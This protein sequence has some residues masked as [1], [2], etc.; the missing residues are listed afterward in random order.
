MVSKVTVIV[1]VTLERMTMSWELKLSTRPGSDRWGVSTA[2]MV[3]VLMD[4][5]V[6]R[7]SFQ[8]IWV[9]GRREERLAR[10]W[11]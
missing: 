10:K 1:T 11:L 9:L 4:G 6:W 5:N 7:H 8:S 3:W 2:A